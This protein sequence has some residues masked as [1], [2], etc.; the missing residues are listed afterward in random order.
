MKSTNISIQIAVFALAFTASSGSFAQATTGSGNMGD[1]KLEQPV[2]AS[3]MTDGEVR[4]VDMNAK[5]ITI[6][7]GAIKNLDMP[8]MT[9][10][11]KISDPAM[12]ESVRKGDKVKFKAAMSDGAMIVTEILVAK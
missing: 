11:F 2:A 3:E 5:K 4:K 8:P 9:M 7:H 10:V 6:K 1:A 12:L